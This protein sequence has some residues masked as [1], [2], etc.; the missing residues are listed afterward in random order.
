MKPQV[1]AFIVVGTS[2]VLIAAGLG[3]AFSI[4]AVAMISEPK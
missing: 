4:L 1:K 2:A 3:G